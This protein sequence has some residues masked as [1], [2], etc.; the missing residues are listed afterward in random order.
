MLVSVAIS[1]KV[2]VEG[3]DALSTVV[4]FSVSNID[5]S[6]EFIFSTYVVMLQNTGGILLTM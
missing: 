6:A 5:R 4:D 1:P 3:F 2:D